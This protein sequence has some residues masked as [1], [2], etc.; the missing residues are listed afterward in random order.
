MES[1]S[2]KKLKLLEERAT[3]IREDIIKTLLKAGSG[4]SAGSLGM[5]DIFTALYFHIL[6]H[7]PR[8]PDWPERDRLVLSNGHIC[9]VLYVTL[10]HAGYFPKEELKTLRQ[11][12]SCLQG[13]P[14]RG[15]VPG[16]ETTSGPLGSG[17]SQ[18]IGMALAA[19]LDANRAV[20]SG[21]EGRHGSAGRG[22]GKHHIY[23]LMSDGEHQE[24]N[25]WEAVMF[26][27]KNRLSNV[28]AII[29]RNNIQIDGFTENVMPLEPLRKK[30]EA[31][32]WHV[33]EINGHDFHQIISACAEAKAI[34]EKPT[35]IIAHTIPGRGVSFMEND[36]TW[37]GKPPSKD[38][39]RDALA[40]LRTLAGKIKSEHQ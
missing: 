2:D 39:A 5:A 4:H 36:Y 1:L 24:G 22:H 23:C 29:D 33:L 17:L 31:F 34:Y 9:P 14:H 26:A 15:S 18:A 21:V 7:K 6:N 3:V 10:A 8:R 16:V 11:I 12:N 40:E 30:Y 25:T 28:T 27:G 13:H 32:N 37:H 20:L 38:E 35:L 19:R